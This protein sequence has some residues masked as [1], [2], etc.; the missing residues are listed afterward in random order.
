MNQLTKEGCQFVEDI[1]VKAAAYGGNMDAGKKEISASQLGNDDLQIYLKYMNGGKDSNEF[2]ANTFGSIYHL[3][4]EEAF[5]DVPNTETEKSMRYELSNGWTVTGT[6][7]LLL[8]DFKMIVDHK[9]TTSTSIASTVKDGRNSSYALQN[10]VYKL[11]LW[12]TKKLKD[13]IAVLPMVDKGYSHFK[14]NKFNQLTFVETETYDLEDI[15]Q[16]LIDKTNKIQEYIDLGI[17]PPECANLFWFGAKGTKKKPMRCIHYC[18]QK[19]NCGAYNKGKDPRK[20][21]DHLMEML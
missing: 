11:L 7:D 12:K 8:H 5:K 3:G 1:L 16:M 17:E 9:T 2:G 20:K 6:V 10:G 18:D 14:K 21:N 4:A 13:Y 15:E 19:E